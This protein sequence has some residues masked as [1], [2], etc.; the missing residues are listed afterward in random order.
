[1]G[2]DILLFYAADTSINSAHKQNSPPTFSYLIHQSGWP[3]I[4][5]VP[6]APSVSGQ[7]I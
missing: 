1:M 2:Y 4:I 5:G 7:S 6:Y 3:V